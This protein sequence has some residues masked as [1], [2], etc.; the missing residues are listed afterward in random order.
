MALLKTTSCCAV[1]EASGFLKS[2]MHGRLWLEILVVSVLQ[3]LAKLDAP[4]SCGS[5]RV[6]ERSLKAMFRRGGALA[7]LNPEAVSLPGPQRYVK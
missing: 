7:V 1:A 3:D 2:R 5:C 4:Q 6:R